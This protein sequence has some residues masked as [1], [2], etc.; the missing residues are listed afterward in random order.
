MNLNHLSYFIALARI[1]HYTK[2]AKSL[3]IS[4]PSLSYAISTLEEELGVP[5]FQKNGR[6]VTMTRYGKM[7]LNYV[8][9]SMD[10]L[11]RGIDCVKEEAKIYGGRLSIG[12][13]Y[14]QGSQFVP[15]LVKEF[16]KA[17]K[18]DKIDFQFQNDATVNLVRDLK[19]EKYGII[20]CSKVEGEKEIDFYPV[21]KEKLIAIVPLDHPLAEKETVTL[22][23]LGNYPQIGFPPASGL[24]YVIRE[25]FEKE[26]IDREIVFE[27]E[28]DSAL[29]GMVSEGFGIGI[30]PDVPAVHNLP[31]KYLSIEGLDYQRYIYMGVLKNQYR[32]SLT[33]EFIQFVKDNYVIVEE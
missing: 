7:F 11:Q 14:T 19:D 2:A 31:L 12:F 26:R 27:V 25:L 9:S 20:I 21:A 29:A 6:N 28:E 1:E 24:H 22:A 16:V 13:I 3:S 5:L 18:G 4:Q 23:E 33:E 30:V 17:R 32:N 15:K 10:V 8:E